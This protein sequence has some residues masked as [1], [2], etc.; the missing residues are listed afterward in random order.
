[1][2]HRRVIYGLALALL[3][4][5][6]GKSQKE[7]AVVLLTN[8]YAIGSMERGERD[9]NAE[10]LLNASIFLRFDLP[11]FMRLTT[12]DPKAVMECLL[13]PEESGMVE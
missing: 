4:N 12:A 7:L 9:I 6:R 2:V 8:K 1:M 10:E 11:Q 5:A 13:G 3:R